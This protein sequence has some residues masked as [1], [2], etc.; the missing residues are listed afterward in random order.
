MKTKEKPHRGA[1]HGFNLLPRAQSLG[2]IRVVCFK[3]NSLS[4]A[5]DTYLFLQIYSHLH[6]YPCTTSI[7]LQ[8][9]Q[10]EPQP[11]DGYL[12]F[13]AYWGD[14]GVVFLKCTLLS[15]HPSHTALYSLTHPLH[16]L[17]SLRNRLR[18][19]SSATLTL[20]R[21]VHSSSNGRKTPSS[22]QN[23]TTTQRSTS[24]TTERRADATQ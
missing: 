18:S 20:I 8:D 17:A 24:P 10:R 14:C 6:L 12:D 3:L 4:P 2:E 7:L 23:V 16:S 11:T 1:T 13:A 5:T 19:L 21:Y 22:A 9:G 15:K